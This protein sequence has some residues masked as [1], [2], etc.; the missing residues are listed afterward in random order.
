MVCG[1]AQ[2]Y[3]QI[4]VIQGSVFSDLETLSWIGDESEREIAVPDAAFKVVMRFKTDE[5]KDQ[6]TPR[7]KG[8]PEVLAFLY[9]CEQEARDGAHVES[10]GSPRAW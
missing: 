5:E 4:W 6:A 3:G 2:T 10:A 7:D 9:P 8:A 1:W